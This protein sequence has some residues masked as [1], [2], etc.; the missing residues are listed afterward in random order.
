MKVKVIAS[1][2][3]GNCTAVTCDKNI[4]LLDAGIGFKRLQRALNFENP[5]ACFITHEHHDHADK[6]TIAEFLKRGVK[7]YMT[8]GTAQALHL[9]AHHNLIF[10]Q[11]DSSGGYVEEIVLAAEGL[12]KGNIDW[13]DVNSW[14][15]GKGILVFANPVTHDAAEPV[16]FDIVH[17][18]QQLKYLVDS[19]T[20][21]TDEITQAE[22]L[23]IETNHSEADLNSAKLD[24]FQKQR[25]LHNHLSIEKAAAFIESCEKEFLEEVHLIHISRRHGNAERFQQII[26][27][28]VG[29]NV[30]VFA[31]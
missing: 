3:N 11:H 19:G 10:L 2:S 24:D 26:Q 15:Y 4:I 7:V 20:A 23:I 22:I 1:G 12:T 25:I 9:A 28:V 18:G 13:A 14:F 27:D 29:D 5:S 16:S 30:K 8:A 6:N 17:S 31:H 21:P